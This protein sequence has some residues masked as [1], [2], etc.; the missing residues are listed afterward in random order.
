[1]MHALART[2]AL[3][4]LLLALLAF[5]GASPA[6][7]PSGV[8]VRG[9]AFDSL[10]F[11]PLAGA[12]IA[13]EGHSRSTL[14]GTDG[15]FEFAGLQPGRYLFAMQHA[16]LDSL[17]LSGVTARV[18]VST[19][20]GPVTLA[21]P[22]FA[23]L[24]RTVCGTTAVPTDTGFVYGTVRDART[25]EPLG[26]ISVDASW[27]ELA[28][29]RDLASISQRR[30]RN[31]ARSDSAGDYAMCGLP[32]DAVI[33]IRG[34][35]DSTATDLIDL[36]NIGARVRRRDLLLAAAGDSLTRGTLGGS[37]PTTTDAR[38]TT[39]ASPWK[40]CRKLEARTTVVSSCA[41]SR[42][43]LGK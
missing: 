31:L 13:I 33:R 30:W 9:V 22:S 26:G 8:T 37:S 32:T 40:G 20:S 38:C 25:G 6:A 2:A 10:N 23:T 7:Q 19:T 43:A 41:A 29:G 17:G 24:W 3:P 4:G 12:F 27:M 28:S 5:P 36:P 39:C 35:G 14:A 34:V 21:V 1:M 42:W 11:R 18:N 16:T 15:Q